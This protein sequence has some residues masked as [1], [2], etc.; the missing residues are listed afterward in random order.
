MD[1]PYE[2]DLG[3]YHSDQEVAKWPTGCIWGAEGEFLYKLVRD[4]KPE[5][6]LAIGN[7]YGC[8]TAHM[9]LAC[10]HNG[11]GHIWAIDILPEAGSLIPEELK[12]FITQIT[13]NA[14]TESIR[15]E[16]YKKAETSEFD[17]LFEDGAHTTGFNTA[18]FSMYPAK[19]IA[20][21]DYRHATA[22]KTVKPESDAVM[23][24]EADLEFMEPPVDTGIGVWFK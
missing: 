12:P 17:L 19:I 21:H 4:K 16:V 24:R 8:S 18:I 22:S 9:A 15:D 1:H 5:K 3:G 14:L 13:E 7:F 10:K 20:C 23:G 2:D 11:V 6:I